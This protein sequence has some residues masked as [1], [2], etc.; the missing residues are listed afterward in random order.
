MLESLLPWTA[1]G[2]YV[3]ATLGVSPTEY[4]Y[5]QFLSLIGFVIAII[6]AL[7][8]IGNFYKEKEQ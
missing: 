3:F 4:W 1:T 8:G 7:T 2:I 5:F 6:L